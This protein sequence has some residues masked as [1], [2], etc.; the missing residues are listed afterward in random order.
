[1]MK[2]ILSLIAIACFGTATASRAAEAA[3]NS[4]A[5]SPQHKTYQN[6]GVERFDALRSDKKNIVLDVRTTKEFAAGHIKDAVNIDWNSPE[7]ARKAG[8]LDRS[9]TYLVHCAGGVRSAKAC[10]KL[11]QLNFKDLVNLEGGLNAWEKA[12]KPVEK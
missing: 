4:S 10:D 3:A 6:V 12:G 1:M 7:F 11:L 5:S 9:K 2:K 8:Q